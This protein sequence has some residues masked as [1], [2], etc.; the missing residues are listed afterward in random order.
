MSG[1]FDT[2]TAARE[3][4]AAGMDRRQAEAVVGVVRA[5]QG[6]F[7]TRG[8]LRALHSD[9]ATLIWMAGANLALSVAILG[10]LL[11]HVL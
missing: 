6:E 9:M 5:A 10:A 1:T 2:L 8:D 7:A 4:E 11:A 3:L